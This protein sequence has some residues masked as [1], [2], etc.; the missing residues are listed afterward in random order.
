MATGTMERGGAVTLFGLLPEP[1]MEAPAEAWLAALGAKAGTAAE[2]DA[3]LTE[4]EA[5]HNSELAEAAS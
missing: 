1:V 4:L 3:W 5:G 2:Y